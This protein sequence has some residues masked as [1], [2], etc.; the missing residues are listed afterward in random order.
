MTRRCEALKRGGERCKS[1][2]MAGSSWCWNHSPEK[3][4]ERHRNA[5]LGGLK[6]G[7]GRGGGGRG[8]GELLE[9]KAAIRA[10]TD[11]VLRGELQTA[12]GAVALQGLNTS[13]RALEIERRT[14]DTAELL[15]R[16]ELLEDRADKLRGA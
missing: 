5:V 10:V 13:L 7:R 4:D 11:A 15:E 2:A 1:A 6:G 12:A 3:A 9:L 14:F 16:L 8:G